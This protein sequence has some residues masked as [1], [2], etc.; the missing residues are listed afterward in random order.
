[1]RGPTASGS[2]LLVNSSD[3]IA[4]FAQKMRETPEGPPRIQVDKFPSADERAKLEKRA[5]VLA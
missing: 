3:A 1:V 2:R 4:I 5:I